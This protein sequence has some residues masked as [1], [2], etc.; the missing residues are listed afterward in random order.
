MSNG[1]AA[2]RRSYPGQGLYPTV[3]WQPGDVLC[4]LMHIG[5]SKRLQE[6]L[7]YKVEISLYDENKGER[8]SAFDA[9]GNPLSTTFVGDVRLVSLTTQQNIS[10]FSSSEAIILTGFN[11]SPEWQPGGIE[12]V[13]LS[14]GSVT[15]VSQD[16]Q[17][18]VHLL[19]TA[20]QQIVAQGDGPPLEEWYPTSW[21][22]PGETIVDTHHVPLPDNLAPGTYRLIVGFYDLVSGTRFG[23]TFDLGVVKVEP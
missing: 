21:W 2:D 10:T 9:Q 22:E 12:S 18:F 14:W 1:L 19:D 4:D 3:L 23:Q 16:Y 20:T 13:T 17:V 15:A 11:Y 6:T 7:V 8:L 5:I